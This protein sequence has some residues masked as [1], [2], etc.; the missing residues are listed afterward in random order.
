M[1][2]IQ[3]ENGDMSGAEQSLYQSLAARPN[4]PI[5]RPLSSDNFIRKRGEPIA[6]A[7][8]MYRRSL[9]ADW[10]QPQ[11]QSP[12][13]TVKSQPLCGCLPPRRSPPVSLSP[14][15]LSP[16]LEPVYTQGPSPARTAFAPT[17]DDPAHMGN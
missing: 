17:N 7:T 9:Q 13:A 15:F 2:W 8:V 16:K 1:A 6:R 10:L 5:T 14:P 3:H 12:L 11:V 4:N